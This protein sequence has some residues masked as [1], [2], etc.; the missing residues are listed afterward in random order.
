M[1]LNEA[2]LGHQGGAS[3]SAWRS[4]YRA[5]YCVASLR[6]AARGR[7][8]ARRGDSHEAIV[9]SANEMDAALSAGELAYR[10]PPCLASLGRDCREHTRCIRDT[11]V[12]RLCGARRLAAAGSNLWL[13]ASQCRV[14]LSL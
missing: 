2:A 5:A 1:G 7:L 3:P 8:G 14:R 12:A 10:L 6:D 9:I 4:G 11:G 13:P